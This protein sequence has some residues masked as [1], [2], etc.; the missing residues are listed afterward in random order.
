M[1][2]RNKSL[3]SKFLTNN[4]NQQELL[5]LEEWMQDKKNTDLFLKYVKVNVAI[6]RIMGK[7]DKEAARKIILRHIELD[8]SLLQNKNKL[9]TWAKYAAAAIIV[10]GLGYFFSDNIFNSTVKTVPTIVNTNTIQPGSS[11]A[12]LTLGDNSKVVLEKGEIFQKN[13]IKSNGEELIYN[14]TGPK[15]QKIEYNYLTI[16]RGGEWLIKLS[17][18]TQVWLNS[19]SQL[20]FPTGFMEGETRQVELIYGEAYFEVTPSTQF[21][22][23]RFKVVSQS[24]EVEV[25]G[26]EF[27]IRAYKNE[28]LTFTTLV[29]GKVNVNSKGLKHRLK[30]NQQLSFNLKTDQLNISFVDVFS[31]ISWKEGIFSFEDKSLHD[32]M[33]VLSRWYDIEVVFE[34]EN[35]KKEEFFGLIRKDQDL[36]KIMKTIKDYGIIKNYEFKNKMLTIK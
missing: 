7:Y 35:I 26:T 36:E 22:G 28:N 32:I 34:D 12:V 16:P 8:K 13:N 4:S 10:F 23:S 1:E 5:R 27:N 9:Y 3:I 15:K 6:N 11:K 20:K 25:L 21:N 2:N 17:D 24:Q 31:E 29:K 33:K 30:P 19:E 14:V 18:G